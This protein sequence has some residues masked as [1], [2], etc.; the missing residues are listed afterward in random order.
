MRR[1]AESCAL[2]AE[3]D[4]INPGHEAPTPEES[5]ADRKRALIGG[6]FVDLIVPTRVRRVRL[7]P[8]EGGAK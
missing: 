2:N 7:S 4:Q 6:R 1:R 8:T 3:S 5:I